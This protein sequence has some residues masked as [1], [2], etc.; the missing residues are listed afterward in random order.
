MLTKPADALFKVVSELSHA[1]APTNSKN[2]SL[3]ENNVTCIDLLLK[4]KHGAF[5]S[6]R[7]ALDNEPNSECF[8]DFRLLTSKELDIVDNTMAQTGLN[9]LDNRY[10]RKKIALTLSMASVPRP[11]MKEYTKAFNSPALSI[12]DLLEIP[13][14][15][16]YALGYR[17]DEFKNK[18]SP[19]LESLTQEQINDCVKAI[20][21]REDDVKKCDLLRTWN[22]S[23]THEVIISLVNKLAKLEKQ[24]EAVCIGL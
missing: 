18:C 15:F 2:L 3:L 21:E 22:L 17:Y 24:A 16:L 19:K 11:S 4:M 7:L 9:L 23:A 14:D 20:E 10:L 8:V 13:E 5:S 6:I 1:D 12:D